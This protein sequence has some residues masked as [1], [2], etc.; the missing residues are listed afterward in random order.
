MPPPIN[1]AALRQE[2]PILSDQ[3]NTAVPIYF[4]SA[5]TSLKPRAVI[6]AMV[7]FYESYSANVGRGIHRL[8]KQANEK[9]EDARDTIASFINAD[10][11]EV[12]FVR[13]AT[14]AINLVA[15]KLGPE[16]R[17]LC[18]R[19][20]HHSN[21]LPWQASAT[22]IPVDLLADGQI[23]LV[24]FKQKVER[25][26]PTLIALSQVSNAFGIINPIDELVKTARRAKAEILI[27]ASQ[28]IP[29]SEIDVRTIDC[30][31]LCFSGHK[32]CGPSG[33]GVLFAKRS[34]R[35]TLTPLNI[36]GGA[37]TS[38]SSSSF[39]LQHGPHRFEA[40]TPFIEGAIALAAA[41]DFL[42]SIGLAQIA[43]HSNQ[44][45][46]VALSR[47]TALPGIDI[48]G[49][50]DPAKR[51]SAVAWTMRGIDS[52]TVARILSDRYDICVRSGYQCAEPAHLTLGLKP[53]VRA[54]FYCYNT[55]G[56]LDILDDALRTI[57]SQLGTP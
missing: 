25:H 23:D 7:D 18:A 46:A 22:V 36:G 21:F 24:D 6:K 27:D 47:L 17:V 11:D 39:D 53:T 57:S 43:A 19:S 5:A 20:E 56:E 44:L 3:T 16:D 48:V 28:G 38:V 8:A 35:D 29:H 54:S 52:H 37:V 30:D 55:V 9:F 34:V 13:N 41:C 10:T 32:M 33:I 40:G 14:E 31:Y 26:H 15:K 45:M 51:G 1:V 12:I 2:F 42:D 50:S 4:D 49:P